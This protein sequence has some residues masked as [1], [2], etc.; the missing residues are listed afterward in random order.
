MATQVQSPISNSLS[1]V[2]GEYRDGFD[3]QDAALQKEQL[4]RSVSEMHLF[5][6]NFE[7]MEGKIDGEGNG[8]KDDQ[9][10]YHF[11]SQIR[12]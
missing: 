9:G 4:I 10:G 12:N 11:D 6:L 8:T 2:Q 5:L 3:I 1:G 7:Q